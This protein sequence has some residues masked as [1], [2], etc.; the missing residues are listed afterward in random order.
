MPGEAGDISDRF[1]HAEEL[2]DQSRFDEALETVKQIVNKEP[3]ETEE[4]LAAQ[5]LMSQILSTRGD[6][7]DGLQLAEAALEK[8]KEI[9]SPFQEVNARLAIA[10]ALCHMGRFDESLDAI[11]HVEKALK[12]LNIVSPAVRDQKKAL[13]LYYKGR[14]LAW[15]G[16]LDQALEHL[17]QSLELHESLG[18]AT[19]VALSLKDIGIAYYYKG[20]RERA[21]DYSQQCLARSK[22]INNKWV[23]LSAFN[24][25]AIIYNDEGDLDRALEYY[26]QNLAVSQEIGHKIGMAV[27]YANIGVILTS[28]GDLDRAMEHH[29]Q[30]LPLWKEIGRKDEIAAALNNIA[31]IHYRKGDVR[32][33]LRYDEQSLTLYKEGGNPVQIA[34]ALNSVIS[35]IIDVESL[36]QAQYHLQDLR[37]INNEVENKVIDIH[38]RSAKAEVLK[39]SPRMRDKVRAQQ[40]FQNLAEEEEASFLTKITA[41]YNLCELLLDEFNAYGE[42]VVFQEA[43]ALVEKIAALTQPTTFFSLGVSTLILHGKFAMVE[44]DL[45]TATELLRKA[46]NLSERKGLGW[47]A[48]KAAKE[49]QRLEDQYEKWQ[50]LI[51]SNTPFQERL[52]QARVEKYLAE[53]LK[54][55]RTIRFSP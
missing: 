20:D 24:N 14:S 49:H 35:K 33:A 13:L 41:M 18:N 28:K 26:Q 11:N 17:Q 2:L 3:L 19:M 25:L 27:T 12:T 23:M 1:H 7:Q 8:S 39:A 10:M 6:V 50:R 45:A 32:Q 53:A 4:K 15:K 34:G 9:S 55:A 40:A 46:K 29:Q 42:E 36:E 5:I 38:Y 48:E 21:L 30:S 22:E 47:L 51:Q 54:L 44:G 37:R 52:Q 16:A 31:E 43:K